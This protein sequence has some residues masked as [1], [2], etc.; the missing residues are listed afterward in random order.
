M[1]TGRCTNI[2][3]KC[4]KALSKEIQEVDLANFVC[5]KC[6]KPLTKV[7]GTPT[8]PDKGEGNKGIKMPVKK[9][10]GEK[11]GKMTMII[12]AAIVAVIAGAYFL[13]SGG[14]SKPTKG[15]I[16]STGIS[17]SKSTGELV[18]GENDTLQA[19]LSPDNATAQLKW[20]TS[21]TTVLKV[22][23]GVITAL[24]PGKAKVGVQVVENK[25]LK[26]FCEYT[27]NKKP[28]EPKTVFGGTAT[29]SGKTITFLHAYTLDLQT[30]EGEVLS[31]GR[32]DRIK[33]AIIE[34]GY[35][36]GGYYVSSTG[37][38][39]YISGLNVKL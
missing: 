26:A 18:V 25:T 24:S 36:K 28:N 9:T 22:V 31:I 6:G 14:S 21:D 37:D 35:L 4:S 1:A 34:N 8:K 33:D 10:F 17:L 13:L 5:S 20:A 16:P 19:T 23:D 27:V 11:Y 32:G 7:N 3:G 2:M 15:E 39:R 30:M 12:V 29:L 38:E